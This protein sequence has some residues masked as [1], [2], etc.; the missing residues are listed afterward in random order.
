MAE[1]EQ[2]PSP[3][4]GASFKRETLSP[5]CAELRVTLLDYSL[6]AGTTSDIQM[7]RQQS[8]LSHTDGRHHGFRFRSPASGAADA[9]RRDRCRLLHV[10]AF[11]AEFPAA[12]PFPAA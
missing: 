4:A 10:G 8:S 12:N 9:V 7:V 3:T 5:I 6:G 1:S 2:K 11:A